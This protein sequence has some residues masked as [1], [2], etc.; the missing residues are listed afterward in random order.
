MEETLREKTGWVK[1]L[2]QGYSKEPQ[3]IY[4]DEHT[5]WYEEKE[6]NYKRI[7]RQKDDRNLVNSPFRQ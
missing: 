2:I 1:G 4:G 3:N 5:L 7:N 6:K